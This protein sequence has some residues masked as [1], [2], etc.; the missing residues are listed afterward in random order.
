MRLRFGTRGNPTWL[1]Y[2]SY[3]A[4]CFGVVGGLWTLQ[5]TRREYLTQH[6]PGAPGEV[7]AAEVKSRIGG[8]HDDIYWVKFTVLLDVP[9]EEC[10]P[11]EPWIYE[12]SGRTR[13]RATF[14]TLE[15]SRASAY[16]LIERHHQKSRAQF[17]YE[18]HGV[19]VRFAGEPLTSVYPWAKIVGTFAVFGLAIALA[20][21]AQSPNIQRWQPDAVQ[22]RC[23]EIRSRWDRQDR[24]DAAF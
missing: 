2:G 13:R 11:H 21:L 4:L 8:A 9:P 10:R 23:N 1:R 6:W 15:G 24:S 7:V 18:P 16:Q 17:F 20:R 3:F 14:N 19:G 22:S 5:L 12:G